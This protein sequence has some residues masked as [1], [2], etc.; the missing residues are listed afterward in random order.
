MSEERRRAWP[1]IPNPD[2][3]IPVTTFPS[4]IR[5]TSSQKIVFDAEEDA[6][7]PVCGT[8]GKKWMRLHNYNQTMDPQHNW[9]GFMIKCD[10][11]GTGEHHYYYACFKVNMGIP[12]LYPESKDESPK[13]QQADP[14]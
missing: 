8:S 12:D 5:R 9:V 3:K 13:E 6:I 2:P 14:A 11:G 7:C 1:W 10:G 4:F